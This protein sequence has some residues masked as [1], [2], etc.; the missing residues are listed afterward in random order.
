MP[1][2]AA[3]VSPATPVRRSRGELPAGTAENGP[4]SRLWRERPPVRRNGLRRRPPPP[5]PRRF[6]GDLCGAAIASGKA[7]ARHPADKEGPHHVEAHQC[8]GRRRRPSSITEPSRRGASVVMSID[9]WEVSARWKPAASGRSDGMIR[10]GSLES[11]TP[12]SKR[13]NDVSWS[14]PASAT[15]PSI[16]RPAST[17]FALPRSA[18]SGGCDGTRPSTEPLAKSAGG[19]HRTHTALRP[20]DFKSP[21]ST[22]SATPARLQRWNGSSVTERLAGVDV[23]TDRGSPRCRSGTAGRDRRLRPAVRR[24]RARPLAAPA[25]RPAGAE[26]E[27]SANGWRPAPRTRCGRPRYSQ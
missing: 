19:G 2:P 23:R 25:R 22:G 15:A 6:T 3:T 11:A 4:A 12:S 27:R 8:V 10:T 24:R 7:S 9:V 16:L 13:S 20:G 17:P 18:S 14:I 21:A 26:D 5:L 1:A